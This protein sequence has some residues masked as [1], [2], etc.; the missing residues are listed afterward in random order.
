[1][2]QVLELLRNRLAGKPDSARLA[3][4]A[5]GGGQRWV[6]TA[7]IL[8]LF[9]QL[10]IPADIYGGTSG[11]GLA[12]LFYADGGDPNRAMVLRCLTRKGFARDGKDVFI[13]KRRLLQGRPPMD[14]EGLI[15]QA[16]TIHQPLLWEN[17]ARSDKPIFLT[18]T[19]R[20]GRSIIQ[21][22]DGTTPDFCK[23][24]AINTSRLPLL[25]HNPTDQTVLWDGTLS[26]DAPVAEALALGATHVLVIDP[27]GLN[28]TAKG[29]RPLADRV[30]M[31]P[32]LRQR[33]PDLYQLWLNRRSNYRATMAHY[34]DDA[35][36]YWC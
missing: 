8:T 4:V 33:A 9:Q 3:I 6:I 19:A 29:G 2:H 1:M 34:Q 17:L 21:R 18:A 27:R 36:V 25:A 20:D 11:G 12:V 5:C 13:Q 10:G 28:E 7:G 23:A 26:N 15:H 30:L 24:A 22:L 31:E 14:L 35:R 16:F 32:Q